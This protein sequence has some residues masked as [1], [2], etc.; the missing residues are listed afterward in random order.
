M[1]GNRRIAEKRLRARGC[2]H[3][4]VTGRATFQWISNL[5][6]VSALLYGNGLKVG[7]ARLA[8]WA[9]VDQRLSAVREA[10]LIERGEG[11]AHGTA[12]NLIHR[13]AGAPPVGR[14]AEPA[15]L[16]KD[17]AARLFHEAIHP[18]QVALATE[19]AATLPLFGNDL[20]QH[21][22]CGD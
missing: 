4:P 17:D 7:D 22:L 3:D 15:E 6:N 10:A 19:A 14:C 18:L 5:P 1:D 20:V 12:R 11:G 9:P 16:S 8:S 13:E 21:E 2:D